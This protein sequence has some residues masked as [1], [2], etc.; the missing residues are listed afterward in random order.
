MDIIL[1]CFFFVSICVSILFISLFWAYGFGPGGWGNGVGF[2]FL[3]F[4][5]ISLH[6][7]LPK[8][9]TIN[10][11]PLLLFGEMNTG[12]LASVSRTKKQNKGGGG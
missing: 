11:F 2:M 6:F 12:H 1:S 4:F 3:F 9:L 10:P 8:K 5:F 7:F